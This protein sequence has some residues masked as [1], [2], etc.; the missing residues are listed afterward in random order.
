MENPRRKKEAGFVVTVELLLVTLT[1]GIGLLTGLSKLRD[2][3]LAELS[4][5]GSAIGAI[6]QSYETVGVEWVD[7]GAIVVAH[8]SG[9]EFT[10]AADAAIAGAAVGGDGQLVGYTAAPAAVSTSID[11]AG[12]GG[13]K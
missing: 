1:L 10:D 8:T 11:G 3:T 2:Q 6:N 12:E 9:F 7:G 13:I 5:T 4:D